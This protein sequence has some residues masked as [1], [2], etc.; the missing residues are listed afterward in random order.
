MTIGRNGKN[1]SGAAADYV[2]NQQGAEVQLVYDGVSNWKVY[3]LVQTKES[4]GLGTANNV[5][6][7]TVTSSGF[8]DSTGNTLR[9]LD[10]TGTVVWG[11]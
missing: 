2:I 10:E 11:N 8:K 3:S 7:A 1:I 5:T 9:I 6:F 4:V